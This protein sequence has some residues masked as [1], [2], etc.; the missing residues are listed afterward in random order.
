MVDIQALGYFA[1][2]PVL[3]SLSISLIVLGILPIQPP[4]ASTT[5]RAE[6]FKTHQ[7]L[8]LGIA[9]PVLAL[10]SASM[11]WNKHIHGAA[12]FTTWHSWCGLTALGWIVSC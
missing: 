9:M 11:W 2:H 12:H 7:G 3:N 8:I 1:P 4:P 6:R 5:V 10:G